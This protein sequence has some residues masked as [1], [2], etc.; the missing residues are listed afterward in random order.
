MIWR[1]PMLMRIVKISSWIIAFFSWL[2]MDNS[3]ICQI[4]SASVSFVSIVDTISLDTI[5][6]MQVQ[7]D[8]SNVS[9]IGT[10]S[11]SVEDLNYHH[12]LDFV[13][14]TKQELISNGT[15]VGDMLTLEFPRR[16][17]QLS[18]RVVC[19]IQN[20]QQAYYPA[21]FIEYNPQ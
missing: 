11:I 3:A 21:H 6:A 20:I 7:V 1:K 17:P 2:A 9:D 13:V 15:L 18:Y 16:N 14:K 5:D 10:V 19:N 8:F 4:D 12:T